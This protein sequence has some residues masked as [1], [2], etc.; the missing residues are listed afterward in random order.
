MES[1]IVALVCI[2]L[3]VVGGMTLSQGFLTSLDSSSVGLEEMSQ[4]AEERMRTELEPLSASQPSASEVELSLRNS[5]QTKLGDFDSW[6]VIVQYYDGDGTSR[7]V[8]LPYTDGTP[9]DNQWS[10]EGIYVDAAGGTPE[11]FEPGI[12]NPAEELVIEL[13]VEPPVGADTVNLIVVTTPNGIAT[14]LSFAG[15]TP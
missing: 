4:R 14:S 2:A 1:A 3:I 9:G 12:V 10:D 5:G 11:V 7:V 8:W 15:Y 13:R 6:D